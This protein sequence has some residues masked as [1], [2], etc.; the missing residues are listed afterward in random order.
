M[1]YQSLP[2]LHERC[3][4][5]KR[6][7]MGPL[8]DKRD[9]TSSCQIRGSR[10]LPR[11]HLPPTSHTPCDL[12]VAA[13]GKTT[14]ATGPSRQSKTPRQHHLRCGR[15]RGGG[16]GR[17]GRR[18]RRVGKLA[19]CATRRPPQSRQRPLTRDAALRNCLAS[20]VTLPARARAPRARGGAPCRQHST[21][22]R[23]SPRPAD[24]AASRHRAAVPMHP[25][26]RLV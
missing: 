12:P 15:G 5:S 26:S 9:P 3:R 11:P 25:R 16:R 17:R 24:A 20:T 21:R 18:G 2:A 19:R 13:C 4:E 10:V 14:S 8:L 1:T 6:V 7:S 22:A 23:A